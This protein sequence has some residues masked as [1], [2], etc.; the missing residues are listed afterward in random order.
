M[1]GER[2]RLVLYISGRNE[3]EAVKRTCRKVV[4]QCTHMERMGATA[5][6]EAMMMPISQMLA[7]SRSAQVGSPLSLPCPNTCSNKKI[8]STTKWAGW[9]VRIGFFLLA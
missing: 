2:S 6:R 3:T 8:Y 1:K 5:S 4:S 9:C 7:V